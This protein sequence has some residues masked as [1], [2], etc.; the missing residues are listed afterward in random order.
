MKRKQ[1]VQIFSAEYKRSGIV[2]LPH[3]YM[4]QIN[5]EVGDMMK[6]E[7]HEGYIKIKNANDIVEDFRMNEGNID[8]NSN[9]E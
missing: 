5:V 9:I 4:K 1:K 3:E 7:I 8:E 2:T 6:F